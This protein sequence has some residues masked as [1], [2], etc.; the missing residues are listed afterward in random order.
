VVSHYWIIKRARGGLFLA[1]FFYTLVGGFGLRAGF[2]DGEFATVELNG[3]GLCDDGVGLGVI[4][5]FD[6]AEA[7]RAA[8]GAIHNDRSGHDLTKASE[9][10]A[11]LFI[12]SVIWQIAYEQF[13]GHFNLAPLTYRQAWWAG[14]TIP[15]SGRINVNVAIINRF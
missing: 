13:L 6:K 8:R 4:G 7:L 11:E 2:A 15:P 9:E 5:H 12:S 14:T 1:A 10:L 3:V